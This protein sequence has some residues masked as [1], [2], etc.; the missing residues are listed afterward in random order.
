VPFAESG[1][2]SFGRLR[3]VRKVESTLG[4]DPRHRP[5]YIRLPV[6]PVSG[7]SNLCGDVAEWLKTAVC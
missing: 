4:T 5:A 6:R 2:M 3:S 1:D 7:I